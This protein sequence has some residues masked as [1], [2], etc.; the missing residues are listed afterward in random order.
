MKP[1]TISIDH[2]L[3]MI[4]LGMF[5]TANTGFQKYQHTPTQPD[6]LPEKPPSQ[7]IGVVP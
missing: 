5:A 3:K 2:E 6:V 1:K 7:P 4:D